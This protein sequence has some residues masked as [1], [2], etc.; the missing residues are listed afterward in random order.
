[1]ASTDAESGK[2]T[3]QAP[4]KGANLLKYLFL[5]VM[6]RITLLNLIDINGFPIWLKL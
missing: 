4:L 5:S 2:P 3:L 6:L 1:M